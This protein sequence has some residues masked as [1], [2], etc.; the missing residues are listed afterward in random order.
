MAP[1]AVGTR[2]LLEAVGTRSLVEEVDSRPP[3]AEEQ[4]T[5]GNIAS[6]SQRW[7]RNA[8]VRHVQSPTPA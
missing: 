1:V 3:A 6:G 7:F 2:S 5:G 4:D 8:I